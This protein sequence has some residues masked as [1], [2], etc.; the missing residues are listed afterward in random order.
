M[1]A[2]EHWLIRQKPGASDLTAA[3][4]RSACCIGASSS[5]SGP[6]PPL[7]GLQ[8]SREHCMIVW[9]A[10][11]LFQIASHQQEPTN[12]LNFLIVEGRQRI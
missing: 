5:Q 1:R 3:H 7:M 4:D 12:W 10:V 8:A 6:L 11:P 9:D 2:A